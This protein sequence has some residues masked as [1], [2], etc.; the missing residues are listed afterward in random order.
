MSQAT[1]VPKLPLNEEEI[2]DTS[3]ATFYVF[4]KENAEARRFGVRP[5]AQDVSTGGCTPPSGHDHG[6]VTIMPRW[7]DRK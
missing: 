6:C 4:D 5:A 7:M 2:S 1:Q 3:L